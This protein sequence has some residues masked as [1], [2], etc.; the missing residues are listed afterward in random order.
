MNVQLKVG[1]IQTSLHS[2]AAWKGES[3]EN[4]RSAVRM[5]RWEELRAK[6]EIRRYLASL[7]RLDLKP[8]IVLLPELSVPVGFERSLTSA[9][10]SLEC[11]VIAGLDYRI[12]TA[13]DK[14]AI[15]N[16]AIVIVP[17]RLNGQLIARRTEYRRV[18]KSYAAPGEI[19]KL[20]A[21]N[22]EFVPDPAIWV[23]DGQGLGKFGVTVCYDFLDLD[24]MVMYRNKIQT[25]FV[26]SYNKDITSFAHV[27]EA[28]ARMVYC[29]VVVCN[30]GRFGGSMAVSPY[31][32][33]YKR[34][35]YRHSGMR[36]PNAQIIEL[37]LDLL[38]QQ[39]RCGGVKG[40][41]SLP[42]GYPE[43]L[44]LKMSIR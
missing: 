19:Q 24:R 31:R 37:P 43:I 2:N 10:E 16:E 6:R 7:K 40:I 36:L 30:C 25:L 35:V 22:V 14:P 26:L 5:S 33:P 42:P 38:A 13:C 21:I 9:A 18:G 44:R 12:A 4:W 8:D 23:I 32:E 34:L 39:Q 15:S 1:V 28:V 3:S 11:V 20:K 29:N 41:K 27:A 17:R